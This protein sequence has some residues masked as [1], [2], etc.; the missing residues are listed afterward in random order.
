MKKIKLTQNQ[1]SLVDDEDFDFLSKNKW[2][3]ARTK[4]GDT[5][6]A[7]RTFWLK[8]KKT[9]IFIHQVVM[10]PPKGY[11]VDHINGNKLDNRKSNLR[12]CT[13]SENLKNQGLRSTNT[14]GY[15]G[16]FFLKRERKWRATIKC[17]YKQYYLGEFLDKEEA[18]QAYIKACHKYHGKYAN[19]G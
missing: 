4:R 12:V 9:K 18:R 13:N 3:A 14:S 15:K 5:F 19:I 16:V 11:V 6:Y 7:G 1:F 17:N 10:N 2:Q 8:G